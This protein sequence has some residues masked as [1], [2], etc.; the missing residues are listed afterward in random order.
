MYAAP[1]P[2]A[3]L[4][5]LLSKLTRRGSNYTLLCSDVR[6]AYFYAK[7]SRPV[8]VQLPEA[9]RESGD[10]NRSGALQ[11]WA[12]EHAG[13]LTQNGFKRGIANTR[14]FFGKAFGVSISGGSGRA[15]KSA[16]KEK[17]V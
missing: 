15:Y 16:F 2:A 1:P 3:C 11:I 8:Y 12:P 5:L 4:K 7:S 10:D 17:Y 6:R 13:T 9:Y 14:L